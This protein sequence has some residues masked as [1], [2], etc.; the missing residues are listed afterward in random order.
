MASVN[1]GF[2]LLVI[3]L[4]HQR[5]LVLLVAFVLTNCLCQLLILYF[6][7]TDFEHPSEKFTLFKQITMIVVVGPIIETLVFQIFILRFIIKKITPKE[8]VAVV[9]S[10]ILFGLW[11][12]DNITL[13]LAGFVSGLTL[14]IL[15]F[16]FR[17]KK[18]S[19]FI[20]LTLF[21]GG[22][23]LIALIINKFLLP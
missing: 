5:L 16:V 21:H 12:S 17:Q 14:A 19:P 10:A 23:N 1:E 8:I 2:L 15:F 11:H 6:L 3:R 13:M 4:S 20:Y 18:W 22:F 9:L 7:P